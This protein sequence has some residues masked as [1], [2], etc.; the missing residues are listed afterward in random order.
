MSFYEK[1]IGIQEFSQAFSGADFIKA[2]DDWMVIVADIEGSTELVK[3]GLYKDVNRIG[4]ATIASVLN[5]SK[6][7][8]PFVFGGDGATFLV[9]PSEYENI[10]RSLS[11]LSALALEEYNQKL[12]VGAVVVSEIRDMGAEILVSKLMVT[13]DRGI[14]LFKGG[15]L[16][17]AD[18]MVKER[19]ESSPK[20]QIK[21]KTLS[22][23]G[24]SCRWISKPSV[25][26]CVMSILVLPTEN[27]EENTVGEVYTQIES[28]C[29][30]NLQRVHPI[31]HSRLENEKLTV[32]LKDEWKLAPMQ[33]SKLRRF[34]RTLVILI[35]CSI[36]RLGL[37]KK[38]VSSIPKHADYQK[39]DDTLRMTIDCTNQQRE[40]IES[41][42]QDQY[43]KGR[44][45]YGTHGSDSALM[46]CFLETL[47]DGEHFHF[48]DGSDG[49]Y[50]MAAKKLKERIKAADKTAAFKVIS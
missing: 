34:F 42:L 30:R 25:N 26:G 19:F 28:I 18:R 33:H 23:K 3:A 8:I 50:T 12:R 10:N 24:F 16:T 38:Y 9:P 5:A 49:G 14:A 46:T 11:E 36:V 47:R 21:E 4:A 20:V 6:T 48:V 17:I 44:L 32:I 43:E 2:P 37:I 35:E 1:L 45:I 39:Y 22:L 13:K 27:T 7:D 41:F 31:N 15:G 40:R 29:G